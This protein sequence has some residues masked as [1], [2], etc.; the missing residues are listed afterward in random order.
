M[1]LI[2]VAYVVIRPEMRFPVPWGLLPCVGAALLIAFLP[3]TNIAKLL[4]LPPM[5]AVG[6]ISYSLY[7]WHWPLITFYRLEYGS[8]L[9]GADTAI[10]IVA[11]FAAAT[12]SY[13]LIERPALSKLRQLPGKRAVVAGAVAICTIVAFALAT[14]II[15]PLQKIDPS[16]SQLASFSD[17]Y[18]RPEYNQQ[19]RRGPCFR[20]KED[21]LRPDLCYALSTGRPNMIIIGDSHAAQY[22]RALVDRF[23][24]YNVI[25]ATAAGCRPLL[26]GDGAPHCTE[27]MNHIFKKV[28]ATGQVSTLVIAG[29][30]ADNDLPGLQRTL[31]QLHRDHP[32]LKLVLIGPTIEYK[33]DFPLLLARALMHHDVARV[34]DE[35]VRQA[36]DMDQGRRD[37]Q[38]DQDTLRFRTLTHLPRRVSAL[39][40]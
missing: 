29:R 39:C 14:P 40:A 2:A 32:H 3:G 24:N 21:A 13:F 36:W 27:V 22:W 19:F 25:Q 7:L 35:V 12:M 20:S 37:R 30:W 34:R 33:G 11:S 8:E 38:D 4:G 31:W 5:V 15:G 17:Y 18:T 9:N 10:L 23:P 1:L 28:L 6:R 16:I 26:N